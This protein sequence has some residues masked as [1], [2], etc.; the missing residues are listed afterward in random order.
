[1]TKRYYLIVQGREVRGRGGDGNFGEDKKFSF[2]YVNFDS[3]K[4]LIFYY[5]PCTS[6]LQ[7]RAGL[8]HK[9]FGLYGNRKPLIDFKQ[10]N[11]TMKCM[12]LKD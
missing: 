2:R 3:E 7:G 6:N 1:M 4:E 12:F 8:D 11:D 9:E 10:K 5:L